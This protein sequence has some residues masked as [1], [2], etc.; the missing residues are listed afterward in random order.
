MAC[1]TAY[2]CRSS[3]GEGRRV[4]RHAS[5]T[6]L[7]DYSRTLPFCRL[8]YP[9]WHH[10]VAQ[11]LVCSPIMF[12]SYAIFT[13]DIYR[14]IAF[15]STD[16]PEEFTPERFLKSEGHPLDPHTY[17]FGFGRRCAH[18]FKCF[19][20]H[21]FILFAIGCAQESNLQITQYSYL[22]PRF[23]L[24]SPS[25]RSS[26]NSETRFQCN[27]H[28]ARALSGMS[29]SPVLNCRHNLLTMR[30]IVIRIPTNV[31]LFLGRARQ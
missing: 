29:L 17:S 27:L 12:H 28:S 21:W 16:C 4:Q 23:F 14:S 22:L 19:Q 13:V 8:F 18:V 1:P 11:R 25:V 31:V 2:V 7:H 30:I 6:I 24:S 5:P 26:T 9:R 3:H 15:D 20:N 10:H